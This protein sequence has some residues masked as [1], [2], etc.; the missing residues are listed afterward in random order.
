M[1]RTEIYACGE[2]VS[3]HNSSE[4]A[5]LFSLKQEAPDS[6]GGTFTDDFVIE[7]IREYLKGV[8]NGDQ[9]FAMM[10]ETVNTHFPKG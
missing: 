10:M 7:L 4:Y 6:L 2:S 3:R 9:P 8:K 1:G 5:A